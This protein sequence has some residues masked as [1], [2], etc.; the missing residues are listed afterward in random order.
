L[1]SRLEKQPRGLEGRTA[2]LLAA[3]HIIQTVYFGG[4]KAAA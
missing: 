3:A 4:L 2:T 1:Y